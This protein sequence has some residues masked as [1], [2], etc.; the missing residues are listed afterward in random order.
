MLALAERSG[1]SAYDCEYVAVAR[2]LD[3][4]LVTEDRRLLKAFPETARR[5][6]D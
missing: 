1:C 4:A 2:R 5:L 6:I 3:V